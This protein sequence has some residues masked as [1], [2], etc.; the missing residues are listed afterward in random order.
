[1][2][3]SVKTENWLSLREFT[4][5]NECGLTSEVAK[6]EARLQTVSILLLFE[7]CDLELVDLESPEVFAHPA[8]LSTFTKIVSSPSYLVK[9]LV[10]TTNWHLIQL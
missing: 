3:S 8:F 4:R 7:V 1:M 6:G 2:M 5:T 10:N 9:S